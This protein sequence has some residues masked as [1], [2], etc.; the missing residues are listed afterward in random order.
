M[1]DKLMG[2]FKEKGIY[3]LSGSASIG[4]I[5]FIISKNGR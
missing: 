1:D 4:K 5:A 3:F 2:K